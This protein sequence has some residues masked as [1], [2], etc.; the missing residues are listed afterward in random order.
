MSGAQSVRSTPRPDL[1]AQIVAACRCIAPS[2]PLDRQI[3]V[4]PHWGLVNLPFAAAD[5]MLRTRLGSRLTLRP[6][7]YLHAWH[8]GEISA[9]AVRAAILEQGTDITV[10]N[11]V[12]ALQ[13]GGAEAHGLALLSDFLDL[14]SPRPGAPPWR[15]L[16]TQQISQYCA[17]Y[18]D[19][20]QADWQR[21]ANGGLY[22]GWRQSLQA[23]HALRAAMPAAWMGAHSLAPPQSAT[24]AICWA[25]DRLRWPEREIIPLLQLC[26]LRILGWASW[27]A[28]LSWEA[29]LKGGNDE[30]LRELLAI[31]LSW[32]VLLDDGRRTED[33]NWSRWRAQWSRDLE[34]PTTLPEVVDL[35]WQRAEEITYQERL[36]GQ[37]QSRPP[38]VVPMTHGRAAAQLVFCID[39]R[40]ERL[41]RAIESIDPQ[42]QTHGIAGFFGLPICYTPIGASLSRPQLPGLLAPAYEVTETTGDAD[43]DRELIRKR[44]RALGAKAA[45]LPFQRL[46]SGA[47]SLV[48]TLGLGYLAA[49]IRRHLGGGPAAVDALGLSAK[50]L[51]VLRPH[52]CANEDRIDRQADLVASCLRA[53]G[54]VGEFARLLVLVAH[55][56]QSTNNPQAAALDCGACGGHSGAVNARVLAGL[57]N[58]EAN[59][60][61]LR[62]RGISIPDD[63]LAVAALHNTTTDEVALLDTDGIPASHLGDLAELRR[64]LAAAGSRTRVERA[65][66]LRLAALAGQ[67]AALLKAV[68]R[69]ARDWAQTRPEWGLAGNAAFIA[70]PRSRTRGVDL[71]GRA[72]LHDYRWETDG[73]G[74]VLEM[75]MTAP[76]V[77]AHWINLQYLA[78]TTDPQRFGSGNKLLHNVACGRIGVFEG[79]TGDL[80]VGLARQSVHDGVRWMHRPLRLSVFIDAPAPMI[81][82]VLS[83]QVIVRHLVENRWL[84]L[85][86]IDDFGVHPW[87]G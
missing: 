69:R 4:N 79:N 70:A 36:I 87:G 20:N 43:H 52:L 19:Q 25:V 42:L 78:S 46:P 26:L 10:A 67:P 73:D 15:D 58:D 66:S 41:R 13:A 27:C 2:W 81:E 3:A 24:E 6:A 30:H 37:L 45:L 22:A 55:G 86:R 50:D 49:L 5:A 77:V 7:E 84:H 23:D 63:T 64:V 62:V 48:E 12:A 9:A 16:I 44:R 72:F 80:R 61:A 59:R 35:I 47:F 8:S 76:M 57:I 40:S 75:I 31:R 65:P 71:A 28:H 85:F 83:T 1:E 54:H 34:R 18:F 56:S 74:K 11:A 39:V 32:E 17:S 29:G 60:A 33:S 38:A 82:R 68:R 14:D 51:G 53:M 21:P